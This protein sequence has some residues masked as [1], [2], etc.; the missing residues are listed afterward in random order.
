MSKEN[1]INE[2]LDRIENALLE[3][4]DELCGIE[5]ELPDGFQ[6][7]ISFRGGALDEI[8]RLQNLAQKMAD[9]HRT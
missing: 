5:I 8:R 1:K 2:R 7:R 4:K 9:L 3:I 6:H